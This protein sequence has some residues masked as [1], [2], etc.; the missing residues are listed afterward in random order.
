LRRHASILLFRLVCAPTG[1]DY[2]WPAWIVRSSAL[3]L[4]SVG[5]LCIG[6]QGAARYGSF[7]TGESDLHYFGMTLKPQA[8]NTGWATAD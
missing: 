1:V 8:P 2:D 4:R 6:F 3:W 5:R 7:T